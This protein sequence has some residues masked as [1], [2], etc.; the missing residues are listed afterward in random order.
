MNVASVVATLQ[1]ASIGIGGLMVDAIW[2]PQERVWQTK[3]ERQLVTSAEEVHL[4]Q[5]S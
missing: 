5:V 4:L 1:G 3:R 2:L